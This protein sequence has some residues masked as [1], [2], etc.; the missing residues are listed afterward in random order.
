MKAP[1]A[2]VSDQRP[3]SCKCDGNRVRSLV[4]YHMRK[5]PDYPG[6]GSSQTKEFAAAA[7]N[8]SSVTVSVGAWSWHLV[9]GPSETAARALPSTFMAAVFSWRLLLWD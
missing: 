5:K 6:F 7:A 8:A 4:S 2:D 3:S 9:H 1:A